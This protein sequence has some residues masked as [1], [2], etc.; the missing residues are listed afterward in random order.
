MESPRASSSYDTIDSSSESAATGNIAAI[1]FGTTSISIAYTTVGSEKVR[2]NDLRIPQFMKLGARQE[3]RVPNA[4]LFKKV[5]GDSS[6]VTLESIGD[7]AQKAYES[8]RD[9]TKVIFFERIKM[10]MRRTDR[11]CLITV[12]M[13]LGQSLGVHTCTCMV[14]AGNFG[15][16]LQASNFGQS[17]S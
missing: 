17:I 2:G 5:D 3:R 4:I 14:C 7:A 8:A 6:K 15:R 13:P 1:D 16:K 10:S 12:V 11:V 9:K